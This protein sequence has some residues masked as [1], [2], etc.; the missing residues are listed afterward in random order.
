[1]QVRHPTCCTLLWSHILSCVESIEGAR[2]KS[3]GVCVCREGVGSGERRGD[4]SVGVRFE[5]E[6]CKSEMGENEGVR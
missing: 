2:G 6:D 3:A 5:R 1:M 4:R